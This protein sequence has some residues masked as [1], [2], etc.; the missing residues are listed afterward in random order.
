[1]AALSPSL[2][3]R[4]PPPG[5]WGKEGLGPTHAAAL[6]SA[7]H[8][9]TVL[10]SRGQDYI[11]WRADPRPIDGL[12]QGAYAL[13]VASEFWRSRISAAGAISLVTIAT[14]AGW[15]ASVCD[16][17]I[18]IGGLWRSGSPVLMGPP[19]EVSGMCLWQLPE[20]RAWDLPYGPPDRPAAIHRGGRQDGGHLLHPPGVEQSV[21]QR[22]L[23]HEQ[24]GLWGPAQL[25]LPSA[26]SHG[27]SGRQVKVTEQPAATC[28][29]RAW[30]VTSLSASVH[31]LSAVDTSGRRYVRGCLCTTC[32]LVLVLVRRDLGLRTCRQHSVPERA[33]ARRRDRHASRTFAICQV[34]PGSSTGGYF[35]PFLSRRSMLQCQWCTLSWLCGHGLRAR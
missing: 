32:S 5:S 6:A 30:C 27:P 3:R 17:A 18:R 13:A 10:T 31:P 23:R 20:S 19:P 25:G 29:W 34:A 11:P 2:W 14:F 24:P 12:L 33:T 26:H 15:S 21:D 1:M 28:L 4:S 35:V 22:E 7:T 16:G 9:C 8:R